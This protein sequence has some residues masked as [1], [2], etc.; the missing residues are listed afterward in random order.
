MQIELPPRCTLAEADAL[1]ARLSE[2]LDH[3]DTDV[4]LRGAAVVQAGTAALQL[5]LALKADLAQQ[6]RSLRWTAPSDALTTTARQLWL[7]DALGL[8]TAQP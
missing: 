2:A 8:P 4:E 7:T 6:G 3:H 5:L 1:K